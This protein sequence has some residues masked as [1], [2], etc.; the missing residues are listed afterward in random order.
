MNSTFSKILSLVAG[1]IGLIAVYFLV[2]IVVSGDE[3]IETTVELQNSVVS[4][5]ISF[6]RI[7]LI[8]TTVLAV[9]FSVWNLI[10]HPK[11]LVRTLMALAVLGVLLAIS[12]ALADDGAVTDMYGKTIK[13]GEAGSTSKWVSTGIWYTVIL[14]AIGI[15]GFLFDFAKSLFKG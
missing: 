6:A 14:G 4:P 8:I 2:R 13:D 3:A 5:Y 15:F 1:L 11:L 12:Y 7:V 9:V 10:K